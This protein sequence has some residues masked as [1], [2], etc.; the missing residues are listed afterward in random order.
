MIER[1][2]IRNFQ[3]VGDLELELGP[4]TTIVGDTDSGKSSMLRALVWA[5]RN[6]APSEFV[7]WGKKEC[8]VALE[9]DGHS[10]ERARNSKGNSYVLDGA[11]FSALRGGVPPEVEKVACVGEDSVQGQFDNVFWFSSTGGELARRLN[12]I[13]NLDIIDRAFEGLASRTRKAKAEADVLERQRRDAEARL[14]SFGKLDGCREALDAAMDARKAFTSLEESH[15]RLL[16]LVSRMRALQAELS[17]LEGLCNAFQEADRSLASYQNGKDRAQSLRNL[18]QALDAAKRA[19][20]PELDGLLS[21]CLE[22]VG[23]VEGSERRRASLADIV[24]RLYGLHEEEQD[25]DVD[26]RRTMKALMEQTGGVCPVCG[27]PY[28]PE[29]NA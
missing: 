4:V 6:E 23:G 1:A 5:L 7:S 10:L 26:C 17:L 12:A 16:G 24:E 9:L 8:S 14:A 28:N 29:E 15:E 11:E 25:L 2:R 22:A 21:E 27:G 13:V 3:A 19:C 18:L 20:S